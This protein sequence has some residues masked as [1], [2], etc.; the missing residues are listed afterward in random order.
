MPVKRSRNECFVSVECQRTRAKLVGRELLSE[1][2]SLDAIEERVQVR[3]CCSGTL[4]WKPINTRGLR[5]PEEAD[6]GQAE[7]E[8]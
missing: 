1:R 7:H 3:T 2:L 5:A 4:L 6:A 8:K